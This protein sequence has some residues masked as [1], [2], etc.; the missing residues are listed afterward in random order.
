MRHLKD[1][2]V[3]G[4]AKDRKKRRDIETQKQRAKLSPTKRTESVEFSFKKANK[5]LTE[6]IRREGD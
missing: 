1:E 2:L 5:L 3:V 6:R 4:R